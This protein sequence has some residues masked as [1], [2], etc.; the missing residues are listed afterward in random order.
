MST[1]FIFRENITFITLITLEYAGKFNIIL[2]IKI[3]IIN[4]F[5]F[6]CSQQF[7]D[8][9]ILYEKESKKN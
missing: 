2:T 8:K 1:S 4:T 9:R 3:W 5:G 7:T 6:I